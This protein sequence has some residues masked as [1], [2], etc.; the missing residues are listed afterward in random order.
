MRV[1]GGA[2]SPGRRTAGK[3]ECQGEAGSTAGSSGAGA[4]TNRKAGAGRRR[5]DC[6]AGGGG[7]FYRKG[8]G[9]VSG[10]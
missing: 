3:M 1:S 5:E 7:C 8:A 10:A 2:D 9:T 6:E 4:C